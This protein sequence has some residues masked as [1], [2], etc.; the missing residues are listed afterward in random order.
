VLLALMALGLGRSIYDQHR[1]EDPPI[2]LR[3]VSEAA[4]SRNLRRT[5]AG[6]AGSLSIQRDEGSCS[7]LQQT[8][9]PMGFASRF[10]WRGVVQPRKL[11]G[12]VRVTV[13]V[14]GWNARF[15]VG[16]LGWRLHLAESGGC[17]DTR[18]ADG[19]D[20]WAVESYFA[21]SSGL[22]V[23]WRA[24]VHLCGGEVLHDDHGS[25]ASWTTPE[26][27]AGGRLSR[28]AGEW[29]RRERV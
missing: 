6:R 12:T 13:P 7:R 25:A 10:G 9:Q 23:W 3:A 1:G 11:R 24:H 19:R 28:C 16:L 15:A 27:D 26:F 8:R 2:T 29:R 18:M 17:P 4:R 20:S 22:P 14:A 5:K 21:E